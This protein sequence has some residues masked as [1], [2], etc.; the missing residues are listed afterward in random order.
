VVKVTNEEWLNSLPPEKK[1]KLFRTFAENCCALC[2]F[3]PNTSECACNYCQDGQ[4]RW[5]RAEHNPDDFDERD[6]RYCV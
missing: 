4:I 3:H 1:V 2:H 6:F 5:L